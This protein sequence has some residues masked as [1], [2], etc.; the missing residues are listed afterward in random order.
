M[1]G[2]AVRDHALHQ[3][4]EGAAEAHVLAAVHC[5]RPVDDVQGNPLT[6]QVDHPHLVIRVHARSLA[7][8]LIFFSFFFFWV[9]ICRDKGR[10]GGEGV[11]LWD[12]FRGY[13]I[14]VF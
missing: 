11:D 3:G 1:E 14:C 5:G 8:Y 2:A 13:N 9:R 12:R 6:P 4:A 10:G 7:S